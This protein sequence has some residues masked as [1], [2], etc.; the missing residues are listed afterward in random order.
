[1]ANNVHDGHKRKFSSLCV[2]FALFDTAKHISRNLSNRPNVQYSHAF[3]TAKCELFFNFIQ[4]KNEIYFIDHRL[5]LFYG[6]M[7]QFLV[8]A[9]F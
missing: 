8:A 1:M 5:M 2:Y 3:N 6:F 4:F 7:S 9:A